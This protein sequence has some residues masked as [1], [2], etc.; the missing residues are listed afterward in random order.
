VTEHEHVDQCRNS[1][2]EGHGEDDG[3]AAEQQAHDGAAA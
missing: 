1:G 2:V 3:E